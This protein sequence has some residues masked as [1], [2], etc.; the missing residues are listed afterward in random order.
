MFCLALLSGQTGRAAKVLM[1]IFGHSQHAKAAF[2]LM[3]EAGGGYSHELTEAST[4]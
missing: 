2:F 3:E 4:P 1:Q